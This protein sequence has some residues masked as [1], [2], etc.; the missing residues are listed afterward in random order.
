MNS[1][2]SSDAAA[3]LETNMNPPDAVVVQTRDADPAGPTVTR[4]G[5]SQDFAHSTLAPL[6]LWGIWFCSEG[7]RGPQGPW[8]QGGVQVLRGPLAAFV[9]L[10]EGGAH[11]P[12]ASLGEDEEDDDEDHARRHGA[13]LQRAHV[14]AGPNLGE[15]EVV[16][17][18][19]G[20]EGEREEEEGAPPPAVRGVVVPQQ[21]GG[22]RGEDGHAQQEVQRGQ[23]QQQG[24]QQQGRNHGDLQV[25]HHGSQCRTL[26]PTLGWNIFQPPGGGGAS[27][28][29]QRALLQRFIKLI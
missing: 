2:S 16:H 14:P 6:D 25:V 9:R 24:E 5:G 20:V 12:G 27:V 22:Q 21:Q 26:A 18:E 29:Q 19:E 7:P 1:I 13:Q 17:V 28:S 8:G 23:P 10:M 4:P 11:N 3:A 15:E